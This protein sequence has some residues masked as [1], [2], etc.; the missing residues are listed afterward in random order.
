MLSKVKVYG[1]LAE[2]LGQSTFEALIR[3][4]AE[5]V[6]FLICNFP[7]LRG[8]MR[9]GYYKVA[10]G[11]HDLQLADSPEQLHYPVGSSEVVSIIPVVTGAGGD[12]RGFGSILLGAAL[13]GTAIFTG[14][15]TLGLTGFT[16]AGTG[17]GFTAAAAAGNIGLALVLGG[18]ASLLSPTPELPGL[19]GDPRNDP[20]NFSFSGVQNTS[21]EGVPVP[22][23]YGEVIV[24]SVVISA[25]LNVE[26]EI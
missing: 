18:T 4:P 9:D 21:R 6:R 26:G 16:A 5:A 15:A 23:A 7:E 1:H 8:L 11:R 12:R 24:G 25:G 13:I 14:G 22:V 19:D 20:N 2:H 3:T 17:L 10:V